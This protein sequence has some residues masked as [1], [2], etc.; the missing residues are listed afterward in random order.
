LTA[1]EL[2]DRL[3]AS[4]TPEARLVMLRRWLAKN[5]GA[6]AER[7]LG[8]MHEKNSAHAHENNPAPVF[9]EGTLHKARWLIEN[10]E[11]DPVKVPPLDGKGR[12]VSDLGRPGFALPDRGA[13]RK[14]GPPADDFDEEPAAGDEG[15]AEAADL[16]GEDGSEG[17]APAPP[18]R[19]KQKPKRPQADGPVPPPEA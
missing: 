4:G 8:A 13:A 6:S 3:K 2:Y 7:M 9:H 5:P 16:E 17:Q 12:P 19:P 18:P 11:A 10:P 14:K 15:A 1:Q